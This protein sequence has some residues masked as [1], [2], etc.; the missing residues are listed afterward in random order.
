MLGK[1]AIDQTIRHLVTVP[2][3]DLPGTVLAI[4]RGKGDKDRTVH[5]RNDRR[6]WPR[7]RRYY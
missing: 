2:D 6:R 5:S 3:V 4:K 1:S 7:R